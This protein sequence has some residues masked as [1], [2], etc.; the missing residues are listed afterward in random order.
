MKD[1]LSG[2][3]VRIFSLKHVLFKTFDTSALG[4]GLNKTEEQVLM[5]SWDHGGASMQFISRK[6][7]LEK[8]S[9]TTIVDTLE[10][11]GLVSRTRDEADR[12]SFIV[13]PTD[14]GS[15]L[16]KQID[17]LFDGHLEHLLGKLSAEQRAEFEQA[18]A[19]LARLIPVLASKE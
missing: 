10:A 14:A 7:G 1:K 18:A 12:R 11:V 3:L 5:I 8:G 15:N 17:A 4:H 19:A 2:S 13:K 6:A 9:V 16:A